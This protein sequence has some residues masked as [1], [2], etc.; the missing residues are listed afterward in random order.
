[1]TKKK[2]AKKTTKTNPELH[3]LKQFIIERFVPAPNWPQEMRIC[4]RLIKKYPEREFWQTITLGWSPNSLCYFLAKSGG[5][6]LE[7]SYKEYLKNPPAKKRPEIV[8]SD[9]KQ[10]ED[11]VSDKKIKNLRDFLTH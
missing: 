1:M 6:L 9:E 7:D 11:Y 3:E 8:L 4:A 5:K 10:G 2:T